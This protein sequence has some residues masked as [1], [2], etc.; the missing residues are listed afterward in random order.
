M[1]FAVFKAG[2]DL[3][4]AHE[5]AE[6][7]AYTQELKTIMFRYLHPLIDGADTPIHTP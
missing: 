1:T 7:V 3:I 2:L 6:R 4:L 5:G